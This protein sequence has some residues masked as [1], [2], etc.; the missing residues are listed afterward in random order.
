MLVLQGIKWYNEENFV[1][2][3]IEFINKIVW[4]APALILI[5]GT[6]LY[7]SILT[8]FSQIT[9]FPRAV[10]RFFSGL[11]PKKREGGTVSSYQAVCTALAATVGMGNVVGVAGAITI[12]GPGAIFWMWVSAVL[13]MVTKCAEATLA[14]RFRKKNEKGEYVGG[15]MYMIQDGMGR[16]WRF[17]AGIYG[18]FGVIAAF[19]VGNATQINAVISSVHSVLRG[20]SVEPNFR[21]DLILGLFMALLIY[22][23]L[24]GGAAGIGRIAER[25]VPFAAAGYLLMS[26]AVL[27]IR[28]QWI[29]DAFRSIFVGAFSAKAVTGGVVGSAFQAVRIGVSRGVFTNE[30]GMGTASIAHAGA[31]VSH[32]V[33]QGL[34]GIF[35]VFADTILICTMTALVIL[36]SGVPIAYGTNAGAELT[37]AAFASCIGGWSNLLL[38]FL[39]CCF[40]IA[41]VLGWGLYGLRCAEYL[42]GAGAWK[43]FLLL[44]SLVV[45]VGAVLESG[46]VW[47][48]AETV[49][50]CM[51]IPNLI[52]LLVLSP[53][54]SRLV[55]EYRKK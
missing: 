3:A 39:L 37:G 26:M 43:P 38:A 53:E 40:A 46:V 12:G 17:L 33:E 15:P 25:L 28:A 22:L 20:M 8:G 4:G 36:C 18:F 35:E 1:K 49:N 9:L 31:D 32:P 24:S 55:A 30:A 19:G 52:A 29:P 50:G 13:G 34:M 2:E 14:V 10:R 5:L 27:V 41:T 44:Q 48:V 6:G 23:M 11:R 42:F 45:V 54:F 16:K 51:A 47:S 21:L 7:L